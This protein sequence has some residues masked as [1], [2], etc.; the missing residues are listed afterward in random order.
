MTGFWHC[1][2][3]IW[4]AWSCNSVI[5]L[6]NSKSVCWRIEN[7]HTPSSLSRGKREPREKTGNPP[8]APKGHE[9]TTRP[10]PEP[11]KI[12][13]VEPKSRCACC[14]KKLEKPTGFLER[15]ITDLPEI[16]PLLITL[17]RLPV[18]VCKKCG[19]K[20]IATHPDLPPNGQFGYN[21]LALVA[22]LRHKGRLP[23]EK[24]ADFLENV[25]HLK[26][27]PVLFCPNSFPFFYFFQKFLFL[28]VEF[29]KS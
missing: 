1:Q 17:F 15:I 28:F 24:V 12:V 5:K 23:C 20:N 7:A 27:I 29:Q 4:R 2:S 22:M 3:A 26:I 18:Q 19:T 25:F 16:L 6:R 10:M 9:G 8:G 14:G 13:D 11:N 21:T